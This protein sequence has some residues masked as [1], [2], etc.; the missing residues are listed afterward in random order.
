MFAKDFTKQ[1]KY[2]IICLDENRKS[3]SEGSAGSGVADSAEVVS[4]A[5][6]RIF[7]TYIT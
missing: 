6:V 2:G 4:Y 7:F 1:E 5:F 3:T